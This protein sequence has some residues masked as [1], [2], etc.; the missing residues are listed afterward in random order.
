MG[1]AALHIFPGGG[2]DSSILTIVFL[3]LLLR[4]ML[5]ETLGYTFVGL[6]VPGYLA[7]VALISPTSAAVAMLE[8]VVTYGLVWLLSE[9]MG[10]LG[11]WSVVF[12]RDRFYAFLVMSIIVRVLGELWVWPAL[13]VPLAAAIGVSPYAPGPLNSV[14]L[15]IVPLAANMFWK[16]GLRR[17]AWQ[18][19]MPTAVVY[20]ATRWGLLAYTNLR[21]AEFQVHYEDI[22]ID[23]FASPKAYIILLVT[24]AL[25]GRINIKV[26]W[27]FGGIL[28]P[29]LIAI[30]WFDVF[31]ALWTFGEAI[32]LALLAG[33]LLRSG[34]LRKLNMEGPRKIIFVFSVGYFIKFAL[35]WAMFLGA[36]QV[37]TI[38]FFGFGYLLASLLA[39][40]IVQKKNIVMVVVP[41][42]LVSIVGFVLGGVLAS[43]LVGPGPV[44]DDEVRVE[45]LDASEQ[46]RGTLEA[47][48]L[49]RSALAG[50]AAGGRALSAMDVERYAELG[51]LA[52]VSSAREG[53]A[54]AEIAQLAA[55]L[56]LEVAVVDDGKGVAFV[57][58]EKLARYPDV[59]G[60]GVLVV[61]PGRRGPVVQVPDAGGDP[62]VVSAALRVGEEVDARA[63]IF[64]AR[65]KMSSGR[66]LDP[67]SD[68][69]SP[70]QR[71][72]RAWREHDV[73]QLRRAALESRGIWM[74]RAVDSAFPVG[75]V[76][77]RLPGLKVRWD[78]APGTDRTREIARGAHVTLMLGRAQM[79]RLAAWGADTDEPTASAVVS[80]R[81]YVAGLIE[82]PERAVAAHLR[83]LG[84]APSAAEIEAVQRGVIE[85]LVAMGRSGFPRFVA[86]RELAAARRVGGAVGLTLEQLRDDR[87]GCW[88]AV[89]EKGAEA[90]EV[91]ALRGFGV[92][93]LRCEAGAPLMVSAPYA[94]P[95]AGTW[96]AAALMADTL[97]AR[98]LALGSAW[99]GEVGVLGDPLKDP[100]LLLA[101]QRV[102]QLGEPDDAAWVLQVR[103]LAEG[104]QVEG[105][106]LLSF[107]Q[108]LSVGEL[109]ADAAALHSAL[110]RSGLRLE[111]DQGQLRFA[112]LR[113]LEDVGA[114]MARAAA[115]GRFAR[116]WLDADQRRALRLGLSAEVLERALARVA[117]QERLVRQGLLERMGSQP[118]EGA[119]LA[120]EALSE[121][122]WQ[123]LQTHTRRFAYTRNP[124]DLLAA[125]QLLEA[126]QRSYEV[127]VDEAREQSWLVVTTGTSGELWRALRLDAVVDGDEGTE[128]RLR[129]GQRPDAL[130]LALASA[131]FVERL[132]AP[133]PVPG[134]EPQEAP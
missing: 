116:V 94:R 97:Q 50:G 53:I 33:A 108:A 64:G 12:G 79:V 60:L 133:A 102:L 49:R 61:R 87:G 48:L 89:R 117:R 57:V 5:T 24:A 115:P 74:G 16:V 75:V 132:P 90:D 42:A 131:I 120:N 18:V 128:L 98:A 1:D 56:E 63:L 88:W 44:R 34:P 114:A 124:L 65:A 112:E 100:S 45:R 99:R 37:R 95:E 96:A 130:A 21:V 127:V 52:E 62:L 82:G 20:A 10:K 22:A 110:A 4:W 47:E 84:E 80:L 111:L 92:V 119:D 113:G 123:A 29:A 36:P 43:V 2:F 103:G 105:A 101:T 134:A 3:G 51:E 17:G 68:A 27:D 70:H 86:G 25:A 118:L 41:T 55:T 46:G 77:G 83:E 126:E 8:A 66:E 14:G 9:G 91:V 81:A 30:A 125:L 93:L 26:G 122:L 69:S 72:M 13:W 129:P 78:V 28:I 85:P 32:G 73:L 11:V 109:E 38:D 39:L 7:S 40:K 106:G 121:T 58:A 54:R 107:D 31:K 6:V 19:L 35:A 67:L 15:V 71:M 76:S 104:R 23:L 59:R